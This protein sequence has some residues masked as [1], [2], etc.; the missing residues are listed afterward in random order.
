MP[1]RSL[2]PASSARTLE[3]VFTASRSENTMREYTVESRAGWF[4]VRARSAFMA[5]K[6][7]VQEHGRGQ[8]TAVR[9]SAELE[10][11]IESLDVA[12]KADQ[13]QRKA[14]HK[15]AQKELAAL[16]KIRKTREAAAV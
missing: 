11:H 15:L 5:Q 12:F 3:S 2:V 6:V 7:G 1:H 8:T 16:A 4:V 10:A 14:S 13:E 9:I